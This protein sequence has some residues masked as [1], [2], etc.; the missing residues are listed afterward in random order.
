MPPLV[1]RLI[2]V[3]VILTSV[4]ADGRPDHLWSR[5]PRG[6]AG[7]SS[8]K[9]AGF[10]VHGVRALRPWHRGR[11]GPRIRGRLLF[12]GAHLTALELADPDGPPAFRGADHRAEHELEHG[13][14]AAG[15]GDD[16]EPPGTGLVV[17]TS[18][19]TAIAALLRRCILEWGV[20]EAVRTDE[21]EDYTSRHVLGVLTDLEIE[22]RPC[23]PYTPEAKPFVERFLGTLT[24]DLFA[25]LPGFSGHDVTQAQ[26]R[27]SRKSFATRRA[28]RARIKESGEDDT[29]IYGAA[30]SA[31]ELKARC[32]SCCAPSMAAGRIAASAVSRSSPAAPRGPSRYARS[33][34]SARWTPCSRSRPAAS[35]PCP[36]RARGIRRQRSP[37]PDGRRR[38]G[39]RPTRPPFANAHRN[40][41]IPGRRRGAVPEKRGGLIIGT[42]TTFDTPPRQKRDRAG[43]GLALVA[44]ETI[45]MR[46]PAANRSTVAS[47]S[48]S[49]W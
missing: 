43:C 31:E 21:G 36:A 37:K 14:L 4:E 1:Y 23:P 9:C 42:V 40:K 18:R 22:H 15:A 10:L 27:R 19:A 46:S 26:A 33:T 45:R 35:S 30:L 8:P 49:T 13:L 32:V 5:R 48:R 11:S 25:S 20:P 24:R 38:R 16:L 41:R 47:G 28:E 2:A 17:P 44:D 39:Q 29:V 12:D 7:R 34:T 3:G 6:S